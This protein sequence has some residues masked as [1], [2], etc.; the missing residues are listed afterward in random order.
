MA[1]P[2]SDGTFSTWAA[3]GALVSEPA[4]EDQPATRIYSQE[5]MGLISAHVPLVNNTVCPSV[6]DAYAV[7]ESAINHIGGGIGTTTRRWAQIPAVREYF[8]S[9]PH[10]YPSFTGGVAF[11]AGVAITSWWR[12]SSQVVITIASGSY[13]VGQSIH[14]SVSGTGYLGNSFNT[15][16]IP[17]SFI[18]TTPI[19]QITGSMLTIDGPMAAENFHFTSGSIS[20]STFAKARSSAAVKIVDSRVVADYWLAG[21]SLDVATDSDIPTVQPWTAVDASGNETT[22][23]A[24]DSTPTAAQWRASMSAGQWIPIE[25]TK[26]RWMGSIIERVVRYVPVL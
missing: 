2:F 7:G 22:A 17:V 4:F 15:R 14:V 25:F 10:Q 12:I 9:Y 21:V 19:R 23:L 16:A 13:A 1:L 24:V 5:W 20:T 6:T 3:H 26:R 11:G 18:Y 8:E